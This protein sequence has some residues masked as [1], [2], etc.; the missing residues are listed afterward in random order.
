MSDEHEIYMHRCLELAL[1][2]GKAVH[3]NPYVG[4]VI[5]HNKRIIA[6]GW[7]KKYGEAHAEREAILKLKDDPRLRE[8][9][10]YVN[11]EPCAHHG[12]TPPCA[13]LIVESRIKE[14]VFGTVDP[15]IEVSGKGLGKLKQG[16]IKVT[17]P[18]LENECRFINR[19][20]L[21]QISK[22]R[23]YIILKWAQSADGYLAPEN[24]IRT[25]IS[26]EAARML[27]HKWRSEEGAILVGAE[28]AVH[29]KPRLTD[30]YWDGPNPLRVFFDSEL[31][32]E[33]FTDLETL[34]F[35]RKRSGTE[36]KIQWI[37]S[38][39]ENYISEALAILQSRKILSLLVEGGANTL[40]RFLENNLYDEIRII[41]SKNMKM[42][43]GIPA[44]VAFGRVIK[45][46]EFPDDLVQIRIQ[47]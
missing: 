25:Q 7:H 34:I 13:D 3:P 23:P 20:F 11:L 18:V 46:I 39:A 10:L 17:G 32:A 41:T 29:D 43:S 47:E 30:R 5:V 28:T 45:E 24:R 9:T 12:K 44:P 15:F 2:A 4:C 27:V 6:E 14:V 19:R 26:G 31:R 8:S 21:T 33:Y 36:G 35:N 38:T 42:E 16:G 40:N 22:N 37:K 1:R